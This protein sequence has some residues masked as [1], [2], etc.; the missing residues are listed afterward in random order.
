MFVVY[1]TTLFLVIIASNEGL[2][3]ERR[4][5]KYVEGSDPGP[6]LMYRKICLEGLWKNTKNLSQDR[7]SSGRDL[8][9]EP[10]SYEV[11]MLTT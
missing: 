10:P 4:F 2:I 1:L 3:S 5:G 7:R 8:K 6:V 9:P 11:E